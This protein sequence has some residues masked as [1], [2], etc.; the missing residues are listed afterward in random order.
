MTLK[1]TVPAIRKG[2]PN[3]VCDAKKSTEIFVGFPAASQGRV[4]RELEG[5]EKD[6]EVE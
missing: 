3:A 4:E 1:S 2:A 6:G 5:D